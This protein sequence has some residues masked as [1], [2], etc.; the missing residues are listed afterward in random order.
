MIVEVDGPHHFRNVSNWGDDI[1]ERQERDVYKM[2][3]AVQNGMRVVRISQEDI[4]KEQDLWKERL[5]SAIEDGSSC[6]QWLSGDPTL[7]DRH[8]EYPILSKIV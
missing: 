6:I 3:C 1:C 8:K 7:Y 4:W 2:Q 5:Q